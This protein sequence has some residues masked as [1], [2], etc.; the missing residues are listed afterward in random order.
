M[1]DNFKHRHHHIS[2]KSAFSGIELV[3]KTELNAK[4][5][6]AMG[7]IVIFFGLLFNIN[8]VEWL[9]VALTITMVVVSEMINTSIEA[10]TDL[11]TNQWHQEAKTAK[12]VAGGMVLVAS[13]A[14]AI[15]GL[16]IF[17]PKFLNLFSI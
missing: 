6:I 15:I 3:I 17:L 16:I 1:N 10:V 14:A 8:Y 11:V 13:A 9:T 4:I 12:D 5:I 2:L 7:V